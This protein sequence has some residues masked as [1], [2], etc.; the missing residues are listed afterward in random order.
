[1]A[2]RTP[3]PARSRWTQAKQDK[4]AVNAA[5]EAPR[6]RIKDGGGAAKLLYLADLLGLPDKSALSFS[7]S[8]AG[9]LGA[10]QQ[11]LAGYLYAGAL[12]LAEARDQFGGNPAKMYSAAQAPR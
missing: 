11:N 5:L 9:Q 7:D 10:A 2:C 3:S 8:R 1:M 12:F 6:S 4:L